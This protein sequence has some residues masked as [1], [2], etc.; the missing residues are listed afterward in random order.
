V[1]PRT[2]LEAL[3]IEQFFAVAGDQHTVCC[4]STHTPNHY[5]D[6]ATPPADP[7]LLTPEIIST[8]KGHVVTLPLSIVIFHRIPHDLLKKAHGCTIPVPD[9]LFRSDMSPY[10][11]NFLKN[12]C[13]SIKFREVN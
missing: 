5:I 9:M 11:G 2:D 1:G 10:E 13:M 4:L 7:Q 12:M 3:K 6:Y 8:D